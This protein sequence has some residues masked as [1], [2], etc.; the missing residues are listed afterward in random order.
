MTHMQ[1]RRPADLVSRC[2]F[3]VAV[4]LAGAIALGI[5]SAAPAAPR[6]TGVPTRGCLLRFPN[7]FALTKRDASTPTGRRVAFSVAEMP[8]NSS[9][10]HIDPT[11]LNRNDGF[12]PGE[13]IIVHVAAL[14]SQAAFK[15]ARIVPV[16]DLAQYMRPNQPLLL[17]DEATGRRQI[18][19]GELDA[20]SVPA[21]SRNLILHPAKNLVPGRRYVVVLR[22]LPDRT[23]A[24]LWSTTSP[25][26]RAALRKAN[27]KQPSVYLTWDFTVASDKSL[28]GRLLQIRNNAF[29][30]L[31]D[32]N[33]ADGVIAGR[34]PSYTITS[35][36]D[37]TTGQDPR[38]AR[39]ISGTFMVPCYLNQ[40][41]CPP[42][43]R[44]HYS[45]GAPDAVPTQIPG[46]FQR[47]AF[48]CNIPRVAFTSPSRI[49]LY[50]HGLLGDH[51]QIE[52]DNIT[53]MS[54]EHDFTFCATDWSGMSKEDIP[55]AI[56]ILKDLSKF[57]SL[58]DRLQQ[59]IL[60]TLY[61]GRLL[62]H[63]LG[64][65]ANPA[66]QGTAGHALL[67]ISH[68]YWDSNSQGAILGG[69]ATAV[70]PDWTRAVLGVATMDFATLL[71]RSVDFDTYSVIFAPAYPDGGQR[72][73]ALSI[74]QML[75]DR[76]ETD[77]WAGHATTSPPRNTPAHTVLMH[78]AVGDHQ[79][80]N[81][82]SDVEA[83]TIG[84][85]AYRPAVD[86]GRSFDVTPLFGI[87][88]IPHFPWSRSAIVYWDGGPQTPPTPPLNIPNR[89]GADPHAFPRSTVAA[90]TQKAAFLSPNGAVINVCGGRPCHTDNY[91]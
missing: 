11:E 89:G 48:Q 51:T 12:S 58:G 3:P 78:V 52:E 75:W 59:G 24:G 85:D 17:L 71:P 6:C 29:A 42:G 82:M 80:A 4:V 65:S 27:V 50:G 21:A 70:A 33:L 61:L 68:L 43:A 86:P 46:N 31:G 49:A 81:A 14:D 90:R 32:T 74:I 77:G 72:L 84:A 53:A 45:S 22:N 30:Q 25:N 56:A 39:R 62:I 13:P 37:F 66:F 55:N 28:T 20:N 40:V 73:V 9:G 47:A 19:W 83:R 38:I 7:D 35:I 10:T 88:T 41:G 57:P 15:R 16:N 60:N 67:N 79:V 44:F 76:G 8:A 54:A 23:P 69:A 1:P 18:V 34:P 64:F 2:G 91:K 26:L 87:P 5:A 63:P 36:Q